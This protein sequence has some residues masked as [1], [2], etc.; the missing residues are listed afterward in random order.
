[1]CPGSLSSQLKRP[2]RKG[3]HAFAFSAE[4]KNFGARCLIKHRVKAEGSR[5]RFPSSLLVFFFQIT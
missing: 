4:I 1:M 5:V 3:D 2:G